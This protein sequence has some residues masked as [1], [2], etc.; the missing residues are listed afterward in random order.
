MGGKRIFNP[1]EILKTQSNF[2]AKLYSVDSN[3]IVDNLD[4]DRYLT[5]INIP[6]ISGDHK[7]ECDRE[8]R[9]EEMCKAVQ[10]L[11]NNKSPGPDGIPIEFYKKIWSSISEILFDS[12]RKSFESGQ[13][14]PSQKKGVITLIPQKDK[15]LT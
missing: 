1:T 8:I 10:D 11:P 4:Y 3:S 5:D 9:K 13:L 12:F 6:I 14:S 2:Y 15:D 7:I